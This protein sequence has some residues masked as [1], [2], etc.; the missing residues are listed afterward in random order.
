M[1]VPTTNSYKYLGQLTEKKG[2]LKL[3]I[4]SRT[5]SSE[6]NA[7][8]IM[9]LAKDSV[10]NRVKITVMLQLYQKCVVPAPIHR[11]ETWQNYQDYSKQ[12]EEINYNNIRRI[13][14]VP[15]STPLPA[16]LMETGIFNIEQIVHQKKLGFYLRINNMEENR[17]I[18][19]V[20]HEQ[21]E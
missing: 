14:K 13:L 1:S 18:K 15:S 19:Q 9:C 7:R 20:F 4:Q 16:L 8:N 5:Q 6:A 10:M 11:A 21:K 12:M 2:S 17:L 3:H